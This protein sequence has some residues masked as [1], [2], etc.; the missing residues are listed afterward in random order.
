MVNECGGIP[1]TRERHLCCRKQF[2]ETN[3][4]AQSWQGMVQI[5]FRSTAAGAARCQCNR[6]EHQP[7]TQPGYK[8]AVETFIWRHAGACSILLQANKGR[9]STLHTPR[10]LQSRCNVKYHVRF[11]HKIEKLN[12]FTCVP[13][14][15]FMILFIGCWVVWSD[16]NCPRCAIGPTSSSRNSAKISEDSSTELTRAP[17]RNCAGGLWAFPESLWFNQSNLSTRQYFMTSLLDVSTTI[18]LSI[19]HLGGLMSNMVTEEF[20]DAPRQTLGG[21]FHFLKAGTVA[22][23]YIYN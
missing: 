1:T 15:V 12:F 4:L 8:Q 17:Y 16:A 3:S 2:L 7:G 6:W 11:S 13:G 18:S 23:C 22:W 19:L 10:L 14:S 5:S 21:D 9:N 20:S